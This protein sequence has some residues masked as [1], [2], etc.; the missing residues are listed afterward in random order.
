MSQ[1]ILNLDL[2]Q[3]AD[4]AVVR[5]RT[6]L[7]AAALAFSAQDQTRIAV[8]VS[9]VAREA[10]N[11]GGAAS[12]EFRLNTQLPQPLLIIEVQSR[13]SRYKASQVPQPPVQAELGLTSSNAVNELVAARRLMDD[14][15]VEQLDDRHRKILLHKFVSPTVDLRTEALRRLE[16]T[17]AQDAEAKALQDS[18][19]QELQVQNQELLQA[20]A[21]LRTRQEQLSA[22][23]AELEDTNRGVVALY[24]ELEEKADALRRADEMKSRFL[25]NTSHELRTPL[26]SIQALCQLLLQR[27]DG[28][29]TPEQEKQVQFISSATAG[30]SELVNDLLDLAKIE[31]G[32]VEVYPSSFRISDLFST[33]RGILRPLCQDQSVELV[34]DEPH[35]SLLLH[36]DEGKVA[37]IIRNFVANSL[38]FTEQ[39]S[40]RVFAE[41]E[42]DQQHLRISVADTG[43]GIR[44][45]HLELIFEEFSQI[46]NHLQKR[47][48]GTGLG[49]PLC[50]K[51]ATLLGG[52]VDVESTPGEG[53]LFSLIL[54]CRASEDSQSDEP[55]IQASAAAAIVSAFTAERSAS[56]RPGPTSKPKASDL[57]QTPAG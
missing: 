13:P 44:S 33:L 35:E 52:R 12:V 30:L 17:L 25:S 53:S 57:C 31:A 2:K 20:L 41:L 10:F 11:R 3:G 23:T 24:A 36:S 51:L 54:P 40:V 43:I 9:E 19:L 5:Q 7:V 38:K 21:E 47:A 56:T 27:V 49:L 15:I 32:K 28:E 48:K 37:Q 18:T 46:E 50:R 22:L 14:V 4:L 26:G 34:F 55:R 45:E 16:A 6:R 29:L 42:D 1:R 8:A 39:G